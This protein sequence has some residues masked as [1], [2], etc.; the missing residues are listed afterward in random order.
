MQNL[1]AS[2]PPRRRNLSLQE[3]PHFTT[4]I[5]PI[6]K[7]IPILTQININ[8][9]TLCGEYRPRGWVNDREADILVGRGGEYV[10]LPR[11]KEKS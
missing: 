5:Q 6:P 10:I 8:D 11:E 1:N 7:K 4:I 9:E 3:S 2:D